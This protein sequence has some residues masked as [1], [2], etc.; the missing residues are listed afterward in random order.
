MDL[1]NYRQIWDCHTH[2]IYSGDGK[3]TIEQNVQAAIKCGLTKIAI[4][5]HG[6]NHMA[7]GVKRE[8][9][10]EMRAEVERLKK[11]YPIEILLGIEANL[12]SYDGDIDLTEEEIKWFDI[13]LLGIHKSTK[14]KKFWGFLNFTLR[15]LMFNT[16]RHSQKITNAYISAI[17]KYPINILVHLHNIVRVDA[18]KIAKEA[19]KT[20]TLI[21]L[22]NKHMLFSEQEIKDMAALGAKFIINSDAH[23]PE[24]VGNCPNV[25]EFLKGHNVP[26]NSIVNLQ[27]VG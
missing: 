18:L 9:I 23:S 22:N 5:D 26:L 14:P 17:K 10:K 15:N 16:K 6:F 4:T 27:K 21:E 3:G 12:I 11:L 25:M 7:Y 1:T 2:T 20:G 13:I 19:V 24:R 8:K